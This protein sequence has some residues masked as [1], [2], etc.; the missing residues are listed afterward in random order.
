M[1]QTPRIKS[2][3]SRTAS[4]YN[5]CG[6]LCGQLTLRMHTPVTWATAHTDHHPNYVDVLCCKKQSKIR[7]NKASFAIPKECVD[8]DLFVRSMQK[9]D[10]P[11]AKHLKLLMSPTASNGQF[12]VVPT[13]NWTRILKT[14]RQIFFS[15]HSLTYTRR[16]ACAPYVYFPPAC[17]KNSPKETLSWY[18]MAS[19][20]RHLCLGWLPSLKFWSLDCLSFASRRIASVI[21]PTMQVLWAEAC[22]FY[23]TSTFST[24]ASATWKS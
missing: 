1:G 15:G 17:K 20:R 6:T 8:Q 16:Y 22:G 5:Y 12:S 9:Q 7:R 21:E 23:S 4:S 13:Y 19:M 24:P 10:A 11:T 18:T 14:A 3:S 2:I